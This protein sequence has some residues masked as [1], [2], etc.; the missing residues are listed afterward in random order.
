MRLHDYLIQKTLLHLAGQENILH[1]KRFIDWRG[2]GGGVKYIWVV[3]LLFLVAAFT[4]TY[5]WI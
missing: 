1:T 2:G 3:H 4:K 5:I